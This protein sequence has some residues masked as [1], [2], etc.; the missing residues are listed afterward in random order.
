MINEIPAPPIESPTPAVPAAP[1]LSKWMQSKES[2]KAEI[3]WTLSCVQ[4]HFSFRSNENKT[5]LFRKMFWDSNIAQQYS[6]GKTK[7]SYL[8]TFGLAPF[9][10]DLLLDTLKLNSFFTVIFDEAFNEALQKEQ[11]DI[12]VR[13]WSADRVVTRYLGSKFLDGG[14]AEDLLSALKNFLTF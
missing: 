8:L 14:K 1:T 12:L 6:L 3:L 13:F 5:E 9:F 2:R 10:K 4:D 7:Q 11:M